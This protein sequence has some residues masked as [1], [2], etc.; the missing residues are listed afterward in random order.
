MSVMAKIKNSAG[1][2]VFEYMDGKVRINIEK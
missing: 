2:D 1:Y